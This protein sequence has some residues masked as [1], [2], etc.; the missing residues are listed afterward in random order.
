MIC[1]LSQSARPYE[2]C[3]IFNG[4]SKTI[5]PTKLVFKI[6]L[7]SDGSID[8]YKARC[9]VACYRQTTEVNCNFEGVY[10]PMAKPTTFQ[11]VMAV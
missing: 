4:W 5:H 11:L 7:A 10:S 3:K 2:S 8:K 9:V 1:D 6:K